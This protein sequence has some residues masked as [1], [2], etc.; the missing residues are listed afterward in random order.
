M[1]D[2]WSKEFCP[3]CKSGNWVNYGDPEDITGVDVDALCCWNCSQVFW[4]SVE[5]AEDIYFGRYNKYTPDDDEPDYK[6]LDEVL[7]NVA[8]IENGRKNPD[9]PYVHY[10]G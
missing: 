4:I 10:E 9:D 2:T 7:M 5:S 8:N 3:A 1:S 6:S